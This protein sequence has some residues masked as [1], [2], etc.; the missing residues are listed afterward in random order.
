MTARLSAGWQGRA[1]SVKAISFGLIGVVN[2]L[3][4][5][6]VFLTARAVLTGSAQAFAFFGGLAGACGCGNQTTFALIAANIISWLVAVSGSY[7]MNS[8][9]TFAA[10]SGRKLSRRRYLT[11]VASGIAGLLANTVVLVFAAE[12]VGLPVWLAKAV[13]VL[14]SFL[15]N[16]SLSHF[17]VFRER[18]EPTADTQPDN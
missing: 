6:C 8:S 7:V 10:E 14:A 9:I 13:A 2:T 3:I 12:I 11:F 1:L 5:Y 15:V 17:V 16:F 4:D 18:S